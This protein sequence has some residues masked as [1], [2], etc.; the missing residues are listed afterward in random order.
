MNQTHQINGLT[1]CKQTL[2][3]VKTDFNTF[4]ARQELKIINMQEKT[5]PIPYQMKENGLCFLKNVKVRS[6][7]RKWIIHII[8]ES[9]ENS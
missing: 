3:F 6:Q 7:N 9:L 5:D 8:V 1:G 4:L 2:S